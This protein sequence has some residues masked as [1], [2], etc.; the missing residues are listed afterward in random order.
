VLNITP[1]QLGQSSDIQEGDL[2]LV[3]GHGG[4]DSVQGVRVV[5][6]GEFTGY[7]EYLLENDGY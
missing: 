3:I 5:F 4:V 6:R 2:V 1:I 7:W